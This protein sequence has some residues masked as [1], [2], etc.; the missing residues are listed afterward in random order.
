MC[1]NIFNLFG[2]ELKAKRKLRKSKS[3]DENAEITSEEGAEKGGK[4]TA[5]CV[6]RVDGGE[7]PCQ[8]PGNLRSSS[9]ATHTRTLTSR[10][11]LHFIKFGELLVCPFSTSKMYIKYIITG[12]V[13]TIFQHLAD[14][15]FFW[16]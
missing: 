7:I 4:V 15:N 3:L 8:M 2:F 6:M 12:L 16:I 5:F 13:Y 14:G 1:Y 9:A 10:G 11:R